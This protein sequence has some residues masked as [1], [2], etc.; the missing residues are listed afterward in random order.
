MTAAGK[1]HV[2]QLV[3]GFPPREVA[4]TEVYTARVARGLV[5]RGWRT[6][7]LASTRAPGRAHGS[8]ERGTVDGVPV[9]RVVDNLPW[10][11]P[12][13]AESDPWLERVATG[14]LQEL[15]PTL[16][17]VQHLIGWSVRLP[18]PRARLMTLHDA[19]GW[20]LRGGTLLRDGSEPCP[21]PEA[22]ACARCWAGAATGARM[23]HRLGRVAGGLGGWVPPERLH[24]A[25]RRLPAHVRAL[26]RVGRPGLPT[27]AQVD[28]RQSAVAEALR[29][30]PLRL[31]PSAFL[32][33]LASA[34]GLGPV[35]VLPH[36]VD[37]HGLPRGDGPVR[38]VGS[39]AWHKGPDLAW[40]AWSTL[41]HTRPATPTF[42]V[43]GPVVDAALA[44]R[45]PRDVLR[46]AVPPDRIPALLAHTSALV[47]GS[48][49]P[50]NAPLV[51]LEARAA[52]CP[53]VAP[54]LGGLPELVEDGVDGALY[55][56]GDVDDC[57]RALAR[58]LELRPTPR[59]PPTFQDHL[60]ALVA[61]YREVL[62]G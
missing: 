7:V 40:R 42:E 37:P 47:L 11:H 32:A 2:V 56:P 14:L 45:F 18:L 50:E 25:W 34:Q 9:I 41:R 19:W 39:V 4:G 38:Y 17:H 24:A 49:W 30:M 43:V 10:R 8:V 59:P 55:H 12:S 48:R 51:V 57:A 54:R 46:P 27:E 26:A 35:T 52:G 6:T 1:P 20:C 60:D 28:G 13:S 29:A 23:E 61:C 5:A 16:V 21:G 15:A 22:S 36:G 31:A 53:V 3:H 44:A 33:G 62:D 58:V